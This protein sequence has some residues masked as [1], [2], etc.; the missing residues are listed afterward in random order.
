MRDL[1]DDSAVPADSLS[2]VFVDT[3]H[4]KEGFSCLDDLLQEGRTQN[5]SWGMPLIG[6]PRCGKTS[7]VV[8]YLRRC[9]EGE[10]GRRPL[11]YFYV[12]MTKDTTRSSIA[13]QTLHE[14]NDPN[15]AFG[16]QP[17]HRAV[18]AL[19]AIRR[20]NPDI[21]IY[22]EAHHLVDSDT[23]KVQSDGVAWFN[24]LLNEIR[25]PLLLIGYQRLE[26]VIRRDDNTSLGGRMMPFPK[27]QPFDVA[28]SDGFGEFQ[29]VLENLEPQL[30]FAMAS[31]LTDPDTAARICMVCQGRLGFLETFLTKAR[32]LARRKGNS[33]LTP[34]TLHAAAAA[35]APMW[36]HDAFNPFEIE[37]L[38]EAL[39]RYKR[40][41]PAT[42]AQRPTR[43]NG[44]TR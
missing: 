10:A 28:D 11:K 33:C 25:C 36:D 12:E 31:N 41:A 8:E 16:H 7:F 35:V 27:F 4:A 20:W 37:D 9:I 42:A 15:P 22:D 5:H 19:D 21:V 23:K 14:A 13:Y 40:K 44:K 34:E 17:A 6:P 30:G 39:N 38:G 29:F 32:Q 3:R 26:Q 24:G 43:T 18:R 1:L 2:R